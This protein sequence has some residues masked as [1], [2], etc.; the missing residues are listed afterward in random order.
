MDNFRTLTE[1]RDMAGPPRMT[2]AA[3]HP[4]IVGLAVFAAFWLCMALVIV[5]VG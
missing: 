4:L 5:A 1:T 3:G 2:W